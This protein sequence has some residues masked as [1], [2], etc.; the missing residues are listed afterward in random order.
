MK[1]C[2][3]CKL[4]KAFTEYFKSKNTKTGYQAYCKDCCKERSGYL[5]EY[6]ETNRET[7][8]E[9]QRESWLK[10]KDIHNLK[11]QEYYEQNKAIVRERGRL[12]YEKNKAVYLYYSKKRK[13]LIANAMPKWLIKEMQ[14]SIKD[15]YIE[16]KRLSLL[17]DISY[18]VDHIVPLNGENVCGLHVPW[19]L[20]ILTAKE[21]LKKSNKY[22]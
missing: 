10:N 20:Q 1:T 9:K 8:R 16:A 4:D 17:N 6:R 18:H 21:N 15:F 11:Q 3:S 14:N 5:K 13:L 12:H 22:E 2:S 19:N 7:L